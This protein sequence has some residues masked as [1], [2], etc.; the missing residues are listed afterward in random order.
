M[1]LEAFAK[2]IQKLDAGNFPERSS[3]GSIQLKLVGS[4]RN[5]EDEDRVEKLKLRCI[6]LGIAEHVEFLVNVPYR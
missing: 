4:C 2:V 1:Q 3:S 5:K 6:D